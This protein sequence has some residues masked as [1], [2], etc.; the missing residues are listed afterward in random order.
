MLELPQMVASQPVRE[1]TKSPAGAREI[2]CPARGEERWST[3]VM[4]A[5]LLFSL[6]QAVETH[7]IDIKPAPIPLRRQSQ[8]RFCVCPFFFKLGHN[9]SDMLV[10]IQG[11]NQSSSAVV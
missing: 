9:T 7:R 5:A 8:Q 1:R 11:H 10:L 2:V 6:N 4:S 3:G